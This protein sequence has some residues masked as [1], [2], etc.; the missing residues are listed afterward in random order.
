MKRFFT[1]LATLIVTILY[2]Q[3]AVA[4]VSIAPSAVFIDDRTNVGTI[5]VSNRS[6]DPQEISIE[7]AFGFPSSDEDG[8]TVMV[9]ENNDGMAA[10]HAQFAVNERIRAFPRAFVLDAGDRQTV[11]FQVRPDPGAE[12]GTYW[13]RVKVLSNP[14]DPDVDITEE[15][16]ITTRITFRFEQIIAAF[17]KQGNASTGVNV[18]DVEVRHDED[19]ISLLPHLERTGNS[20]FIGSIFARMYGPGGELLQERQSTTTAYFDVVRRIEFDTTGF[21]PGDYRVE[22]SFETRRSD[23]SPTDL[24]QAPAVTETVQ[25]TIP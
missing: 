12:D 25:V 19:R 16:G 3:P 21:E 22:L 10:E 13:T 20:P 15:E 23:V 18:T 8:N 24:V 17:Y 11:R 2:L 1:I 4:Q 14:Q 7:F 5:Y 9:Y 6:N